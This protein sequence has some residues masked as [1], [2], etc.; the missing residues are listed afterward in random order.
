MA[1]I[2]C[3]SC[4]KAMEIDD[5]EPEVEWECPWCDVAFRAKKGS[6]GALQFQVISAGTSSAIQSEARPS[7]PRRRMRKNR[8][9]SLDE[10]P[11]LNI[12]LAPIPF[13]DR[14]PELEPGQPP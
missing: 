3:P 1:Q 2:H 13:Q 12:S 7:N 10:S 4:Y 6:D 11:D 5:N 8:R 14:F 9:D